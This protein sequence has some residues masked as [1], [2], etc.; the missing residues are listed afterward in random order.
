M[1]IQVLCSRLFLTCSARVLCCSTV[2]KGTEAGA[3]GN[4]RAT[5]TALVPKVLV[6][7]KGM[8]YSTPSGSQ[9]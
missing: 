8:M 4:N 9:I 1:N 6:R 7:I 2:D 5:N 3:W